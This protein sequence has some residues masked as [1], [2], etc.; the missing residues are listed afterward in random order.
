MTNYFISDLHF[1][2]ENVLRFDNA[3]FPDINSRDKTIVG[4]WNNA[5]GVDDDVYIL[6]DVSFGNATKT[7]PLLKSLNGNL[8]LIQGNHEK[9]MKNKDYRNCFVEI[10]PYKEITDDCSNIPGVVLCH[11]PIICFNNRHRNWAH[12]YGHIHNNEFEN[13]LIEE[14]RK[15]LYAERPDMPCNMYNVGCM[16]EYMGYTPRTL[17]EIIEA[18]GWQNK[19]NVKE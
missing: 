6:G 3:P 2:H 8:H 9:L 14:C 18:C 1:F 12:L 7:I 5:V 19:V 13:K 15:R 10:T 17:T 16:K 11:Y 4:N